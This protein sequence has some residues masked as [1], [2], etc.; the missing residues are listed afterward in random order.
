MHP[1]CGMMLLSSSKAGCKE[2][3]AAPSCDVR[4]I[5]VH[6]AMYLL[7]KSTQEGNKV[8]WASS[9]KL[10][11]VKILIHLTLPHI[12]RKKQSHS[13]CCSQH[14]SKE[15]RGKS[16]KKCS[17]L[18]I[19]WKVQQLSSETS[20]PWSRPTCLL[21]RKL[22][23]FLLGALCACSSLCAV[24]LSSH[25]PSPSLLGKTVHHSKN[26][27]RIWPS[28]NFPGFWRWSSAAGHTKRNKRDVTAK[29]LAVVNEQEYWYIS[30]YDIH[31][32]ATSWIFRW[33]R[34]KERILR[35]ES[36]R[37]KKPKYL[38]ISDTS[39]TSSSKSAF[40]FYNNLAVKH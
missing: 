35:T 2:T 30:L 37:T 10:D 38:K 28:Q 19:G 13:I 18:S 39:S 32:D 33:F 15:L 11:L 40:L 7:G 31:L 27:K 4:E 8:W 12:V 20:F 5:M 6:K 29:F 16:G 25:H 34:L 24:L 1:S 36:Q 23:R 21:T 17:L 9:E 14:L 22:N 3:A 26:T